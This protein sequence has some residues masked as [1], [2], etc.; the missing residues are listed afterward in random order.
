MFEFI[1][2]NQNTIKADFILWTGDNSVHADWDSKEMNT[3]SVS[4]YTVNIT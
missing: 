1:R 2:D 4:K 3:N